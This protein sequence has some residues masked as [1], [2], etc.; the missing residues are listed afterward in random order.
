MAELLH[1]IHLRGRGPGVHR[2][3]VAVE[4]SSEQ[5]VVELGPCRPVRHVA[6]V[7]TRRGVEAPRLALLVELLAG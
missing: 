6:A 4:D 1:F 2:D 7:T 3:R 5:A